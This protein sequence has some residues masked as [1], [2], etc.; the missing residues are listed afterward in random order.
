MAT[1]DIL[2][3]ESITLSSIVL[4]AAFWLDKSFCNVMCA[5]TAA[6]PSD[7]HDLNT[8]FWLVKSLW[9]LENKMS[10]DNNNV[11]HHNFIKS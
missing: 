5:C 10:H 3:R 1:A 8:A 2:T 6:N 7:S 9:N 11:G 4:N